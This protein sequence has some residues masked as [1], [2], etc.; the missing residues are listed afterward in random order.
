MKETWVRLEAVRAGCRGMI[1]AGSPAARL[2]SM[3]TGIKNFLF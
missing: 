1:P 2:A 3:M